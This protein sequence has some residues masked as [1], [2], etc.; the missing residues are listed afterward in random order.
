M[1]KTGRRQGDTL[2]SISELQ[3]F[4]FDVGGAKDC[5]NICKSGNY[6]RSRAIV[7]LKTLRRAAAYAA[8]RAIRPSISR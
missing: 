1:S 2:N 3:I 7:C 6:Y 4:P 5:L 8:R